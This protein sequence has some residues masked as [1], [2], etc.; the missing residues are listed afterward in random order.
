MV[1]VLDGTEE[2]EWLGAELECLALTDEEQNAAALGMMVDVPLDGGLLWRLPRLG[3]PVE[4]FAID[5]VVAVHRR[6]R[7]IA[8]GLV[9]VDEEDVATG[10][11]H[12]ED[13]S[14][15]DLRLDSGPGPERGDDL[16]AR[17]ASVEGQRDVGGQH[18]W[19]RTRPRP[20]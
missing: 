4:Q 9:Q 13:P 15:R 5:R 16:L 14:L 20:G 11:R 1:H 12:P 8:R 2:R 18:G 7:V 19:R 17:V 10:L 3:L 6:R